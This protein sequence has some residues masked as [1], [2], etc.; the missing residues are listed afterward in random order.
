M[1]R[2]SN[3][4][5]LVYNENNNTDEIKSLLAL[6]LFYWG[7]NSVTESFIRKILVKS[8]PILRLKNSA[9]PGHQEDLW[10]L[11]LHVLVMSQGLELGGF[12]T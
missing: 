10:E 5:L 4:I 7:L 11:L 12:V 6:V 9:Q 1:F 2:G 8:F 3:K